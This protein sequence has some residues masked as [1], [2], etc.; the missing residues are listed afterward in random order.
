MDS[1]LDN[2]TASISAAMCF[3]LDLI[4]QTSACIFSKELRSSRWIGTVVILQT[5][6]RQRAVRGQ[7]ILHLTASPTRHYCSLRKASKAS[8][9][10]DVHEAS[11]VLN[12]CLGISKVSTVASS[13]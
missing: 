12:Y 11:Q 9:D 8:E 10:H 3:S 7:W 13:E 5:K 4:S 6:F 2:H 1:T